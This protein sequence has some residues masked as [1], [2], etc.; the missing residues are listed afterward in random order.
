MNFIKADVSFFF[1]KL[2]DI[3]VLILRLI[4]VVAEF[5]SGYFINPPFDY[6]FMFDEL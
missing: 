3:L 4:K 1:L 6:V 2:D 5:Y